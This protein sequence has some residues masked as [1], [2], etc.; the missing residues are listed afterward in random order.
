GVVGRRDDG[1]GSVSV[2]RQALDADTS[3]E[4]FTFQ[5]NVQEVAS[6][7]PIVSVSPD[8]RYVAYTDERGL[9]LYDVTTQADRSLLSN[10][11]KS[12]GNSPGNIYLSPLWAPAGGWLVTT[13]TGY[14]PFDKPTLDFI[15]PLEPITE[16]TAEAGGAF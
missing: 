5:A 6:S 9:R 10:K 16:Y 4:L 12:P 15:R 14:P 11:P 3:E 1:G 2:S 13:R 8:G 7:D